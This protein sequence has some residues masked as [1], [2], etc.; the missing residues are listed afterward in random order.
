MVR[1][2]DVALDQGSVALKL[3]REMVGKTGITSAT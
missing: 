3:R 1:M 2:S